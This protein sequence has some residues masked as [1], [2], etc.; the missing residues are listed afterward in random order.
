MYRPFLKQ[1]SYFSRRLNERVG[2]FFDLYPRPDTENLIIALSRTA[3][4]GSF[5]TLMADAIPD[6]HFTGDSVCFARWRYVASNEALKGHPSAERLALT[7]CVCPTS[8]DKPFTISKNGTPI[9]VSRRTTSST[10][11]T[12]CSTPNNGERYLQR[13][14]PNHQ[15]GFLWQL[16][17]TIS[18]DSQV[19]AENWPTFISTTSPLSRMTLTKCT[20]TVGIRNCT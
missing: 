5:H 2:S 15:R 14:S 11:R 8:M 4:E 19:P 10:S 18:G 13:T 20:R 3:Q 1:R 9:Q 12:V 7:S 16:R 6:W 17:R